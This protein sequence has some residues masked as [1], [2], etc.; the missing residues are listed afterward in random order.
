MT[1]TADPGRP[2]LEIEL[3]RARIRLHRPDKRNRIEPLDLEAILEHTA[4]I[5]SDA[6]IRSVTIEATGSSWCSGYHLGALAAGES[7]RHGFAEACDAVADLRVPTIAV[8]GGSVHGGGTDLAMSC[9]FRIAA[10]QIV[11]AMP[12]ARIGLQYYATGLQRFV[13]RIGP[14]ATKRIFLTGETISTAELLRIGYLTEVVSSTELEARIDELSTAIAQLAP[15]AISATK[16]AIDQLA[17]PDPDLAAVQAGH[18]ASLRSNEHR[19][20]MASLRK[21]R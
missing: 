20:A 13:D 8:L 18:L 6:S 19:D 10:D 15:G 5:T 2:T 21:R 16:A 3:G 4:S 17:G 7:P 14:A 1:S 11:L 12:A 9:D